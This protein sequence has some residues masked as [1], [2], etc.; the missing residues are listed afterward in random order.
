MRKL[1]QRETNT[2][3]GI[4][5]ESKVGDDLERYGY[6]DYTQYNHDRGVDIIFY[7]KKHDYATTCRFANIIRFNNGNTRPNSIQFKLKEYYRFI[8]YCREKNLIPIFA[9][10]F[11]V[12]QKEEKNVFVIRYFTHEVI[13]EIMGVGGISISITK[14][15]YYGKYI[16]D[17]LEI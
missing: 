2:E 3:N 14:F 1:N 12:D 7:H 17:V 13:K 15:Y 8:D 11:R 10:G 6:V 16:E 9:F 4:D 5:F